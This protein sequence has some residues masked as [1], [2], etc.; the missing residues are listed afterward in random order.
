[1]QRF[2]VLPEQIADGVVRITGK[3]H[4]HIKNVLR[5][6]PGEA[7]MVSERASS[8]DEEPDGEYYCILESFDEESEAAVARIAYFQQSRQE[9][10]ASITLYQGLPKSE[11]MEL[12][13]QKAVELGAARIV[14]VAMKRCVVKLEAG[15]GDKKT[16]RWQAIAESAAKQCG[17][18]RIPEVSGVLSFAEAVREAGATDLFLVPYENEKGMEETR[19]ILSQ[20]KPG[21]SIAIMIGPE[22]GFDDE[23]I[24]QAKEAGGHSISLGRR[25]LRTETA[26]MCLLS[27]LMFQLDGTAL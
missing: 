22:G 7:F 27:V 19:R 10:P 18:G 23:E 8:P 14:P 25:I 15:R 17:R 26:G 3:D 11:K 13:I 12:I 21:Q 4:Q 9:L 5:M 24:R 20:V 6:R 16:A 2:F 1:M